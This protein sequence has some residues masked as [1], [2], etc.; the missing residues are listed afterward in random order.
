MHRTGSVAVTITQTPADAPRGFRPA[1]RRTARL[2]AG[3][4]LACVAVG[5]NVLIYSSLGDKVEVVQ[6]TVDVRAGQQLTSAQVRLVEVDLDPTVP[7]VAAGDL[8]AMVGQYARVHLA[9]GTLLA[10]QLVQPAPL[11]SPGTSV[12]AVD[13][14]DAPVPA[15]LRERSRVG[16]VVVGADGGSPFSTEGRVVYDGGTGQDGETD[17][18]SVEVRA[19]DAATVAAATDV[20]IVL[21]DPGVDPAITTIGAS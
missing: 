8:P 20:R 17:A 2:A 18:L 1:P 3:L 12:V 4:A 10:A 19:Q 16:L 11:V 15:G 13:V 6:L 7:T 5:G 9:S 21:L 14:A